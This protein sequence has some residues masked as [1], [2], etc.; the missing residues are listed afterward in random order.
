MGI[1]AWMILLVFS[2]TIATVAQYIVLR[3]SHTSTDC[4][5]VLTA[6]GALLG[7]FTAQI[8]YGPTWTIGPVIDG[9]CVA[10]ALLGAVVEGAVAE[11]T[12]RTLVGPRQS[13]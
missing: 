1:W 10:P 3:G 12:Y 4:E 11:L 2:A 6:G 7:G 8:W 9:L 5:W 13:A